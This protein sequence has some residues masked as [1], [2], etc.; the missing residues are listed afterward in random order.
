MRSHWPEAVMCSVVSPAILTTALHC[1]A[2]RILNPHIA[3]TWFLGGLLRVWRGEA[4]AAVGLFAQ[5][6]RLSL[7]DPELYRI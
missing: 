2:A 7:L 4:E 3:P 6:M 1:F 5:A